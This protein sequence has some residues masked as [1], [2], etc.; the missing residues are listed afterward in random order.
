METQRLPGIA[1][2]RPRSGARPSSRSRRPHRA[3]TTVVCTLGALV[4]L[5]AV[6]L[7]AG[8]ATGRISLPAAIAGVDLPS[9][10]GVRSANGTWTAE[11]A[12]DALNVRDSASLEAAVIGS[13]REGQRVTVTGSNIDGFVPVTA[14]VG[15]TET[16]GWVASSY[17]QP[18]SG[19]GWATDPDHGAALAG[20]TAVGEDSSGA[21]GPAVPEEPEEPDGDL[22]VVPTVAPTAIPTEEPTVASTLAPT[23]EHWIDVDRTAATVT[24]FVGETPVAQ[25]PALIGRDPAPDGFYSTAVG[26]FHVFSMDAALS[27]TPFVDDVY[28]TDWVGFDPLRKNGFHSPVRNAD[29]SVRITG[30]T[31][32]M[33]CVRLG[34]DDAK[35]LYAFAEIGMRVEVHD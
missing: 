28:L 32:T 15:G 14:S 6:V 11:V 31:V 4:I 24:L 3:R 7:V 27:S 29:G 9:G 22:V 34:E 8:I 17:L 21:T 13:L 19:N 12:T 20:G 18:I 16:R 26:T 5:A 33:G 25:F 23:G 2:T 10:G 30:G 1:P 35:T